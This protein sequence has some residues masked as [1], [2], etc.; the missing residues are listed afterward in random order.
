VALVSS[1]LHTFVRIN[2]RRIFRDLL[3]Y[4]QAYLHFFRRYLQ[5]VDLTAI[6]NLN[7]DRRT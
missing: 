4:L 5:A 2:D 3:Q 7:G 6:Q 1:P